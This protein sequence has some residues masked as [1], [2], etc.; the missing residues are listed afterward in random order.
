V[1]ELVLIV[2]FGGERIA[3]PASQVES[4]VEVEALTPVPLAAPHIAGLSALRSRVLTA[5]DCVA[6]LG[7]GQRLPQGSREAV[8]TVVEGHPYALIVEAVEDVI[9]AETGER[10]PPL[11]E[12]G[13]W[14]RIA[15]GA[16]DAG[17]DLLLLADTAALVRGCGR[18]AAPAAAL[19]G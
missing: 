3:I 1:A 6:S 9:E 4:V 5:V 8:V 17:G 16:V 15:A 11:P 12:S 19:N 14:G 18:E 7:A 2:R 13:G 10:L